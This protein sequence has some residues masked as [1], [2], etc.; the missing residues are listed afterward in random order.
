MESVKANIIRRGVEFW[1]LLNLKTFLNTTKLSFDEIKL[2]KTISN[3]HKTNQMI[4]YDLYTGSSQP[5]KLRPALDKLPC[6]TNFNKLQ[7][8]IT[9]TSDSLSQTLHQACYNQYYLSY[10]ATTGFN[11]NKKIYW[12]D[13]TMTNTLSAYR[14]ISNF[15]T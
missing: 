4:V 12:F 8:F 14:W 9:I 2:K 13:C 15:N 6:S 7:V 3:F 5:L 10:Q 11:T 1:F